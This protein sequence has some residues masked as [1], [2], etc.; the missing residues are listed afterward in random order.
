M[1]DEADL[2]QASEAFHMTLAMRRRNTDTGD[3]L[4][5]CIDCGELIPQARREAVRGCQRCIDCQE[6]AER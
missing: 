6:A 5:H 2:A 3:S 1:A 4:T